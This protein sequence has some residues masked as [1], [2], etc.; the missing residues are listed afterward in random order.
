M[1]MK[2]KKRKEREGPEKEHQGRDNEMRVRM[3]HCAQQWEG[4]KGM[5]GYGVKG[6]EEKSKGCQVLHRVPYLHKA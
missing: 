2:E 4:K 1:Y 6:I 5:C 3:L